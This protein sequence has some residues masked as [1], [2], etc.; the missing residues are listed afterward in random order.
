MTPDDPLLEQ[1]AVAV[2]A[3]PEATALRL[4]YARV[5]AE[6]GRRDEAVDQI[7]VAIMQDP[8]NLEAVALHADLQQGHGDAS[9]TDTA[10]DERGFDWRD[11]EA[12]LSDVIPPRFTE[13]GDGRSHDVSDERLRFSDV[14]GMDATKERIDASFLAPLRHPELR[15]F[16]GKKL[17]GGLLL[18][19]PPGCGKTYL[20][21]AVAGEMGAGF[22]SVSISDVLAG[23]F[24]NDHVRNVQEAFATARRR[25]PCVLFIDELDA[26]GARRSQQMGGLRVLVNQLLEELDGVASRGDDELFALAATNHPWD[27]DPAFTRPGRLDQSVFVPPPD[28][29]AREAILRSSLSERPIERIDVRALAAATEGFS[30][31]DL[32]RVCEAASEQVLMEIVRTGVRRMIGMA[33]LSAA[34][35]AARPSIGAWLDAARNVVTFANGDGRYDELASWL[36][37][38]PRR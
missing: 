26:L 5:L 24:A 29:A 32:V 17:R 13:A 11:A 12:Q 31:A 22:L 18:Y 21:R 2:A 9:R 1:L 7:R 23:R 4:H 27:V 30:G 6:R 35:R 19:G 38:R 15:A 28:L 8:A 3:A 33:D 25:A 37:S 36:A 10:D 14:A 16:L 34:V 20:A